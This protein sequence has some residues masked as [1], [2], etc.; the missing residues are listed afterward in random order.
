[1][2]NRC[3]CECWAEFQDIFKNNLNYL[4]I[5]EFERMDNKNKERG[6]IIFLKTTNP[7]FVN[8]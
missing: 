6:E 7:I 1:M 8:L 5:N 4:F 2:H 3:L